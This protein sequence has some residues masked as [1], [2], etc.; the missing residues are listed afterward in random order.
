MKIAVISDIH[1]NLEAFR[2]VLS[3]IGR[4][5]AESVICLGDCIGYGPNPEEVVA[6]VRSLKIPTVMGNHELGIARPEFLSWFNESARKSILLTAELISGETRKWIEEL[7]A[8]LI[9]HD[10]LFVHGCPPDSITDYLF[11]KSG[12]QLGLLL[13]GMEQ[14]I[15]FV[16]HT[17][18]LRLVSWKGGRVIRAGLERGVTRLD[19]GARH[20]VNIGSVG[21]PRDG[22]RDA[23]YVVWNSAE[24]TL[25]VRFVP[26]DAVATA[27]KIIRVG[28]PRINADRLL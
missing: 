26:Y 14:R 16:G 23:K 9:F 2:E 28:F 24:D 25:D 15:C 18:T 8:S 22:N 20:I 19:A 1:A 12:K 10:G 5:G 17:H 6:L 7:E 27:E 4:S 11:E 3:D 21:Q 13:G